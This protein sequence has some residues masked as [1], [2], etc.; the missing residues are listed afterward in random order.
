M[1]YMI[2]FKGN[3]RQAYIAPEDVAIEIG[4]YVIVQAE[5]G[6]QDTARY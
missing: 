2:E 3:R 1:E 6:T 5:R 4:K